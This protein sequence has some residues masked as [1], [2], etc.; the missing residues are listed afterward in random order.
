MRV[1]HDTGQTVMTAKVTYFATKPG[2][3]FRV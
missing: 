2:L 3:G 1:M